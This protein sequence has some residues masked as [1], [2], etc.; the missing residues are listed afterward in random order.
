MTSFLILLAAIPTITAL[1]GWFT[2]WAA[3]KMIF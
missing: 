2:N 1:I 3:V